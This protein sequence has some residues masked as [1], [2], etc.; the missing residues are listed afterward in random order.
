MRQFKG[1]AKR[2]EDIDIPRIGAIIGVGEDEI[3][4]VIDVESA[5]TGF[6]R[7]GRPR[8][9]FEPHVFYREL[10]GD[11][12]KRAV[13][14]GLAYPKWKR[15]YP[16]DSYPRLFKAMAINENA[17][18]CSC[19]WGLGQ[20]MGFNCVAAGYPTAKEMVIAFMDDEDNHLEAIISFIQSKNLD[21]ELRVHDWAAFARG[22]NGSG[23]RK[24]NYHTKLADAYAKWQKISDTVWNGT[25]AVLTT[26]Q[27][28][29]LLVK[30]GFT[31]L[32][33]DG[34]TGP[35]TTFATKWFQRKNGLEPDGLAGPKTI[36]KLQKPKAV[37]WWS[38]LLAAIGMK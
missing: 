36:E 28:Q 21:D 30:A 16:K 11:Q 26:K 15:N 2:I 24:N 9:L 32:K 38:K 1:K 10:N 14:A 8:M 13:A 33:V 6:D 18:L 3:H 7:Q 37:S 35:R 5:G 34:K 12:R 31:D 27:V 20:I 4:A 22:Y 19:S 23:Y 29:V 25:T 17:A